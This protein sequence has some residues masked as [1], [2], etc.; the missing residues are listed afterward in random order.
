[1]VE[2]IDLEQR[3]CT[4]NEPDRDCIVTDQNGHPMYYFAIDWVFEGSTW[5]AQI[6]AY[7]W[8]GCDARR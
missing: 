8:A 5:T 6:F 7:D 2:I 4:T 3:R 1:M